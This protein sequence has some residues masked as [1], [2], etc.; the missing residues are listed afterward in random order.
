MN[1]QTGVVVVGAGAAGLTA[2]L[3]LARS[4]IEVVVVERDSDGPP[5]TADAALGVWRR[6]GIPQFGNGHAFHGLAR[7][8]LRDRLPHVLDALLDAGITERRFYLGIPEDRRVAADVDLVALQARRPVFDWALYRAV[9]EQPGVRLLAGQSVVALSG[10][11]DGISGVILDNGTRIRS[12]WVVDATGHRRTLRQARQRIG[13]AAA[14]TATQPAPTFYYARHFRRLQEARDPSGGGH[15]GL[16][17]DLG[18]LRF[19]VLEEDSCGFVV[20]MNSGAGE[21]PFRGL[22]NT[23][24]WQAGAEALP[25]LRELIDPRRAE[26]RSGVHTFSG[27]GNILLDFDPRSVTPGLVT[28]GDALCQ[29][30]P[31]HGWGISIALKG[32]A[33]VA[34][35][36]ARSDTDRTRTTREVTSTLAS[37]V[38]PFFQS[39]SAEDQERLRQGKNSTR[40]GAMDPSNPLFC[41]TVV[42]RLG[43]RDVDLY[44]AAQQR[45]H[46]LADPRWLPAN[47]NLL[48]TAAALVRSELSNAPLAEWPTRHELEH[49]VGAAIASL[50]STY[51]P[52]REEVPR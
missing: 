10:D 31:T 41:R 33:I 28:V 36:L 14:T 6:P 29:T 52:T 4:G 49:R 50:A 1:E 40:G 21:Q 2:A 51:T 22:Q 16:T 43:S 11:R 39:A 26:P 34:D 25:G 35:A 20:T 47:R 17:G 38:R 9:L 18:Y 24:G 15:F 48:E 7:L 37:F 3:L 12:A 32:A 44:R 46:L 13:L 42:Y 5:D 23:A 19:S 45:I 30:N 27:R 8:I